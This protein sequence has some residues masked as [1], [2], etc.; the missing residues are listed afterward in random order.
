MFIYI[1]VQNIM[2]HWNEEH[3]GAQWRNTALEME[4]QKK[5]CV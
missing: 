1:L 2:T 5:L 4:Q 3:H